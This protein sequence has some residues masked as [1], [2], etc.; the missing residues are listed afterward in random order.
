MREDTQVHFYEGFPFKY[1][2]WKYIL[3][4]H[5]GRL[6]VEIKAVKEGSFPVDA[7]HAW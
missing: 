4:T 2:D 1:D 5:Q 7:Q 6:P 3:D